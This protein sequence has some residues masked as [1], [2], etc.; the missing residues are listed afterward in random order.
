MEVIV[1][2]IDSIDY[3]FFPLIFVFPVLDDDNSAG[4][5]DDDDESGSEDDGSGSDGMSPLLYFPVLN[6]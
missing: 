3:V 2:V 1:T 6:R 5:D 4:S